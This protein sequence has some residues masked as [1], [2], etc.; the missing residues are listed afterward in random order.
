[1][2][3]IGQWD[4]R[5]QPCGVNAVQIGERME[6]LTNII[7]DGGELDHMRLYEAVD[8]H[9]AMDDLMDKLLDYFDVD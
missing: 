6:Q 3:D 1:M 2:V 4:N 7:I 9:L 8:L 5:L